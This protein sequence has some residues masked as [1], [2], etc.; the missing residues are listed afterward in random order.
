MISYQGG[1]LVSCGVVK[2]STLCGGVNGG[3]LICQN[4]KCMQRQMFK[5]PMLIFKKKI[6]PRFA[7]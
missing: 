3:H 4:S 6:E 7:F 2:P 5:M 1:I